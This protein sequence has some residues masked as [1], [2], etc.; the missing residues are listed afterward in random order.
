MRLIIFS[1][2]ILQILFL[3]NLSVVEA[4]TDADSKLI[5]MI[6][7]NRQKLYPTQLQN[8]FI[9]T[10]FCIENED[11]YSNCSNPLLPN[12]EYPCLLL[13]IQCFRQTDFYKNNNHKYPLDYSIKIA[14]NYSTNNPLLWGSDP[15]ELIK[16][17][18]DIVFLTASGKMLLLQYL[19]GY[20]RRTDFWNQ[21]LLEYDSCATK[22]LG[23][24]GTQ[25]AT[26]GKSATICYNGAF[27]QCMKEE[28]FYKT[29][30]QDLNLKHLFQ[31][32]NFT[33]AGESPTVPQCDRDSTCNF[34]QVEDYLSER[35]N[36]FLLNLFSS[37]F[38]K[39]Q[40]EKKSHDMSL[41]WGFFV[42]ICGVVFLIAVTL[43][44]IKNVYKQEIIE[45]ND[46]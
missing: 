31:L 39:I 23:A 9:D 46:I 24:E 15:K 12:T 22:I 34:I 2:V 28:P 1:L 36:V 37:L 19:S 21:L 10:K 43:L 30:N 18:N 6:N 41:F 17:T 38:E 32:T 20:S 13:W 35:R 5:N 45:N 11:I 7:Y 14:V 29:Y 44:I 3:T 27:V 16:N 8:F 33:I 42:T 25:F 4:Q 26:C 40:T